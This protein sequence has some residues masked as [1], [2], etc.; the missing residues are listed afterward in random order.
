MFEKLREKDTQFADGLEGSIKR[1]GEA[2]R[3]TLY[4]EPPRSLR[5]SGAD[6]IDWIEAATKSPERSAMQQFDLHM[7]EISALKKLY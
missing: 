1:I 5:I 2:F 4:G 3:E 6:E 7:A